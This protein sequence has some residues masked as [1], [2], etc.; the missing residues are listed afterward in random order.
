MV[1]RPIT[2]RLVVSS[3]VLR[4]M[5]TEHQLSFISSKRSDSSLTRLQAAVSLAVD[6]Y[7]F[8]ARLV[9]VPFTWTEW[10]QLPTTSRRTY[11]PA[12][13]ALY[14]AAP[15]QSL[16]LPFSPSR[17]DK[18]GSAL[19]PHGQA[20]AKRTADRLRDGL[21]SLKCDEGSTVTIL[22][23][24]RQRYLSSDLA[25]ALQLCGYVAQILLHDSNTL[26]LWGKIASLE[27]NWLIWLLEDAPEV[28]KLPE[29]VRGLV[30]LNRY[31]VDENLSRHCDFAYTEDIPFIGFRLGRQQYVPFEDLFVEWNDC[32]LHITPLFDSMVPLVRFRPHEFSPARLTIESHIS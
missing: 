32:G 27:P 4:E 29:S 30:T 21:S 14:E 23:D 26:R 24:V 18:V 3:T 22:A 10:D 20:E 25:D 16:V 12:I 15:R 1:R 31:D 28:P 13:K 9:H 17:A 8:L 11:E 7:A 6:K 2:L 5:N 19:F